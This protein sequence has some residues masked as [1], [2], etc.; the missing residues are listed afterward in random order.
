MK[1]MLKLAAIGMLM[2]ASV[3]QSNAASAVTPSNWVQNVN[4]TLT[5][6]QGGGGR[7]ALNTKTL[8]Q[9]MAG[10]DATNYFKVT[11]TATNSTVSTNAITFTNSTLFPSNTNA[12]TNGYVGTFVANSG[13][14]YSTN[15]VTLALYTNNPVTFTFTNTTLVGTNLVAIIPQAPLT[16]TI[17]A[18]LTST[19]GPVFTIQ[20]YSAVGTN[21]SVVTTYAEVHTPASFGAAPKLVAV[22][23]L[24]DTNSRGKL[25]VVSK[26][27][28]WDVTGFFRTQRER[29]VTQFKPTMTVQSFTRDFWFDD[30]GQGTGFYLLGLEVRSI[31]T[32]TA[33][34][35]KYDGLPKG[36]VSTE[37][38]DGTIFPAGAVNPTE[39][40]IKGGIV[41]SGGTAK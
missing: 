38:G 9:L 6:L 7:F 24:T 15:A 39:F 4:F 13:T 14:N 10:V 40:V 28:S 17:S 20:G 23:S 35:V 18:V 11:D 8:I 30:L 33:K 29:T 21:T 12:F 3:V 27:G 37:V 16:N 2:A 34:G 19:N 5:G 41:T 26:L 31:G 32:I 22:D 1:K 36:A 25:F